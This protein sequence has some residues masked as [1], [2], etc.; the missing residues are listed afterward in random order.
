MDI[1]NTVFQEIQ[2]QLGIKP[3]LIIKAVDGGAD[4]AIK[5]VDEG[6]NVMRMSRFVCSVDLARRSTTEILLPLCGEVQDLL[7]AVRKAKSEMF[8]ENLMDGVI[9]DD[10]PVN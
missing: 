4:I 2:D 7:N 1:L 5:L 8:Y 10:L 6:G 9:P 3:N